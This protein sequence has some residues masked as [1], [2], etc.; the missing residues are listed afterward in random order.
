MANFD[1]A[2]FVTMANEGGY[3]NDP[4]DKGGETYKGIARKFWP[5][6]VGWS[7]IDA[8]KK[9]G[10]N[11]AGSNDI[12]AKDEALQM[13]VKQFYKL[14]FWDPNALDKVDNQDIASE[15]FDTGVNQGVKTAGYMLQE[16]LNLCNRNGVTYPDIDVDGLIGTTT[17]TTLNGKADAR[18]VFNTLNLLQG[19]KYLNIMRA[20]KSQEKFWPGWLRRIILN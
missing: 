20:N 1:K 3:A 17:L 9:S 11:V 7:H 19:E 10:L 14:Y 8:Y 4:D 16:A 5:D 6:W 15:L 18:A 2:Y 12:L 13:Y